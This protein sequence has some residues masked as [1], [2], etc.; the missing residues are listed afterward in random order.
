MD[1]GVFEVPLPPNNYRSRLL[2]IFFI[3]YFSSKP[4][5]NRVQ[6]NIEIILFP[7][8]VSYKSAANGNYNLLFLG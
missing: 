3:L 5:I 6:T 2:I 7:Y 4:L 8:L 1:N